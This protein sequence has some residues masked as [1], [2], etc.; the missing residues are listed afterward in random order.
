MSLIMWIFGVLVLAALTAAWYYFASRVYSGGA[1]VAPEEFVGTTP[2]DRV[3][4][5]RMDDEG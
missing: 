2:D 4:P 5:E 1:G 3:P